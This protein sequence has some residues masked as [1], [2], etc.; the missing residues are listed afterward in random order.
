M[1]YLEF[2]EYFKDDKQL[3]ELDL[4]N[5]ENKVKII[6]ELDENEQKEIEENL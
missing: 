1:N 3:K 5:I 2:K 4:S 6:D